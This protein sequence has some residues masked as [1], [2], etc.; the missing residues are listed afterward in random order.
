M[1]PPQWPAT[2]APSRPGRS[3]MPRPIP[4]LPPVTS[5]VPAD[6]LRIRP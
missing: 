1:R 5:A 6:A 4:R 2:S 3:A